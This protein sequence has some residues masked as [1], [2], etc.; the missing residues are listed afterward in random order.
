MAIMPLSLAQAAGTVGRSRSTILRSIRAGNLS[1]QRDELTG[2]WSI[3]VA[4][5]TRLFS[6][7]ANGHGR[8]DDAHGHDQM[9]TRGGGHPGHPQWPRPRRESPTRMREIAGLVADKEDLN[10]RLDRAE[11]ERREMLTALNAAQT[12]MRQLT[13]QRSAAA[14]AEPDSPRTPWRRFLRA[15]GHTR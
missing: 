1:A 12:Q 9:R 2:A 8:D 13:D 3:D 14:P 15:L 11:D 7:Q 6:A 5:L 4:E 10:R